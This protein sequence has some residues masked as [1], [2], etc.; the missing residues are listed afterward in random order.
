MQ[1]RRVCNAHGVGASRADRWAIKENTYLGQL[2]CHPMEG[3]V[4]QPT[5]IT[6]WKTA[7]NVRMGPWK[8]PLRDAVA[9]VPKRRCEIGSSLIHT[10]GVKA[11]FD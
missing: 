1:P 5:F 11:I 3:T 7:T 9:L 2:I 6:L 4:G 10:D 8:K